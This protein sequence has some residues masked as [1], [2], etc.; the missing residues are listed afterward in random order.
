MCADFGIDDFGSIYQTP[1][2]VIYFVYF[3]IAFMKYLQ[4]LVFIASPKWRLSFREVSAARILGYARLMDSSSELR[5][6]KSMW[7]MVALKIDTFSN[8]FLMVS[9][10]PGCEVCRKAFHRK[11]KISSAIENDCPER[12][13]STII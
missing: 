9:I 7:S 2:M 6:I 13:G 4:S 10:E 1:S 3:S 8:L 5:L 12:F 11:F